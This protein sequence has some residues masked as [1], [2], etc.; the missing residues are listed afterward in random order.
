MPK[1]LIFGPLS[2]FGRTK[3]NQKATWNS[4]RNEIHMLQQDFFFFLKLNRFNES[5]QQ[6]GP[7]G[8]QSIIHLFVH[9]FIFTV[10]LSLL[11]SFFFPTCIYLYHY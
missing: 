8:T 6:Q 7:Q 4:Q 11:R 1:T 9:S 10:Q 5:D 2:I 3:S